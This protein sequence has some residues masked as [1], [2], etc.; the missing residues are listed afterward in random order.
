MKNFANKIFFGAFI[1]ALLFTACKK[2][3]VSSE[4]ISE[5]Q[6]TNVIKDSVSLKANTSAQIMTK[7]QVPVLC[8]HRIEDGKK[9]DYT[10]SLST[11]EAHLKMLSDSGYHS[12][13][14]A[15]LYDYL[16][17][18]KSLPSHPF[19]IT[20]DD[21][22]SEHFAVAAPLLEKYNYRASFFIMTITYNKKNYM[23]KEQ[24]AELAQRGHCI[25]LHSWDHTMVTKYQ[26]STAWQAQVV[27]PKEKLEKIVGKKVE[28][29]AHPNG[30]YNHIS[31]EELSK[32][33]KISFALSS[34]R[35]SMQ[36]LQSVRRIIAPDCSAQALLKSM[37]NSFGGK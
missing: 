33:F 36:P 37:K 27:A 5:P 19:L 6:V 18:N 28:Y 30:V 3:K 11:F 24:I 22:R 20:F 2:D 31:A 7:P 9:G 23:T 21:S 34:K 13:L 26:D 25:G 17:Y 12:I 14:P 15:Q 35:D 8:Y 10:V 29:W 16:V 32:Y 1:F 4:K